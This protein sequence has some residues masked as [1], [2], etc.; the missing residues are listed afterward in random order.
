MTISGTAVITGAARGLGLEIAR[1]F[2]LDDLD[3]LVLADVDETTAAAAV[4]ELPTARTE[5]IAVGV[6]VSDRDSVRALV[7]SAVSRTGHLDIL[8]N[9]AGVLSPNGRIHN[10]GVRDWERC[11]NVNLMGAVNGIWA[12]VP[13]MR[14]QGGGVI[15]NTAS[16]AGLTPFPYASAYSASKAAIIALT[17]CAAIE[18]AR[19][20]IRVNCVCPG[21]FL[22]AIHDGLPQ[23]AIDAM[24]QKHPL[25]LG[26][27]VEIAGA[28][29]YLVGDESRWTTGSA[30][31][32]DGGYTAQ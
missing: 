2:L 5:V 21:S 25:G 13:H 32:V 7:E 23:Q 26:S 20:N 29:A 27:A 11:I 22:S 12:A 15:V 16:V 17:K 4:A 14:Q 24:A 28:F 19:D 1:R 8:V 18:Y 10:L 6:D 31:I 9:N 3:L 30:L